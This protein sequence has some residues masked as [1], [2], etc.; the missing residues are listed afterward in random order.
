[1]EDSEQ[2]AS[3]CEKLVSVDEELS[4]TL[5][6]LQEVENESMAKIAELQT[7]LTEAQREL[8]NTTVCFCDA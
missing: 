1:L 3:A 6:R 7:Q 8:T 4:H 2:K 5:E